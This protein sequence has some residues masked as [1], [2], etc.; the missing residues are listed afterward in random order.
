M[1][2]KTV[3][4]FFLTKTVVR[5]VERNTDLFKLLFLLW[6][7]LLLLLR[8]AYV[9]QSP[10]N[11]ELDYRCRTLSNFNSYSYNTGRS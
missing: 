8:S 3:L 9:G 6:Y 1:P 7:F 5:I 11:R 4:Q 2:L 10:Q